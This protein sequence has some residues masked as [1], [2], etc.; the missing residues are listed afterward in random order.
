M[1]FMNTHVFT[2]GLARSKGVELYLLPLTIRCRILFYHMGWIRNIL[3]AQTKNSPFSK[4][5][6]SVN[7]KKGRALQRYL[8]AVIQVASYRI[9][10]ILTFFIDDIS[11]E[12]ASSSSAHPRTR[13]QGSAPLPIQDR[14]RSRFEDPSVKCLGDLGRIG[15]L[16]GRLFSGS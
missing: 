16:S 9:C 15:Q 12:C 14:G 3:S 11:K 13:A 7:S 4:S 2:I 10:S 5:A 6:R 1:F 8:T